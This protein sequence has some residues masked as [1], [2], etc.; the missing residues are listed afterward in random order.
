M[1]AWILLPSTDKG[2]YIWVG[3]GLFFGMNPVS[4]VNGAELRLEQLT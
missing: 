2:S 1:L 4:Q 3:V